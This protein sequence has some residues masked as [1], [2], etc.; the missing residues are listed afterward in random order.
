[1]F[2]LA[3]AVLICSWLVSDHY[4]PWLSFHSEAP[5]FAA[6]ALAILAISWRS[7]SK[8]QI[9]MAVWGIISI[10]LIPS[11]QYASGKIHYFGDVLV[12]A[13]YI[14]TLSAAW[15]W[16]YNW[17]QSIQRLEWIGAIAL[18]VTI[19]G[20]VVCFQLMAQWIQVDDALPGWVLHHI[21][22]SRPRANI[23]Q[24][25]QA[26]TTLLMACVACEI[27]RQRKDLSNCVFLLTSLLLTLG[28]I[29]TQSRTALLSALLIVS[30]CGLFALQQGAKIRRQVLTVLF[31]WLV[32]LIGGAYYFPQLQWEGA[33]AATVAQ[34]DINAVG[35]RPILWLQLWI[36]IAERPWTGWGWLQVAE[37]QQF[38]AKTV[39]GI[40]QI[41]YS[42]NILLDSIIYSG[43]FGT[44]AVIAIAAI[45]FK[46]RLHIFARYQEYRTV[47]L[48]LIPF[49][50]HACLEF[51]H[52]YAYFLVVT[53]VAFGAIDYSAGVMV[54]VRVTTI[55]PWFARVFAF[56]WSVLL[57]ALAVEYLRAEE[58]FRINR[59]ENARIGETAVDYVPPKLHLLTQLNDLLY[60]MR[61]RAKS[62]MPT[63]DLAVLERISL[64][65][66]WANLHYRTAL[67]YG[68]NG[69][70]ERAEANLMVI[71][72]LF[73]GG[74]YLDVM[75]G[76]KYLSQEYPELNKVRLPP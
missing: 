13:V 31:L 56:A 54:N 52:A 53:G 63:E 9:P 22:K 16:G 30:I 24:P 59:F 29:L 66:T 48:M 7:T 70:P 60:A 72:S 74:V 38:G 51:P 64:R 36:A 21:P 43:L 33:E 37:A 61:L 18:G 6:T 67:A 68:L 55:K 39:S 20:L 65:Y 10:V 50:V 76:W 73:P 75:T 62:G 57:L 8:L 32:I 44:L 42:H 45:W 71:K 3:F 12:S 40:E 35:S 2:P 14:L 26:A 49:G 15:L 28:I 46:K 23:G 17:A 1:M 11:I 25:N 34:S 58:D 5:A 27:L 47:M 19:A 41:A 69:Y 4:P